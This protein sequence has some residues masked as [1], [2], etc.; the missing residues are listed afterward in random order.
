[1]PNFKYQEE[2]IA[3]ELIPYGNSW[4]STAADELNRARR[5]FKA[6]KDSIFYDQLRST[7]MMQAGTWTSNY[8]I[9]SWGYDV[10]TVSLTTMGPAEP[11]EIIVDPSGTGGYTW[12]DL[13]IEYMSLG[14]ITGVPQTE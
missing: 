9:S 14:K 1:M 12:I 13:E 3:K 4:E 2:E 8:L 6:W 5:D 10:S 7:V 11:N